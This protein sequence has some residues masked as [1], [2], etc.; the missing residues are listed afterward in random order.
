M[1]GRD[2]QMRRLLANEWVKIRYSRSFKAVFIVLVL[3]VFIFAAIQ[4]GDGGRLGDY[5]FHIPFISIGAF[6]A[7]GSF[8]YAALAATI[9]GGELDRKS[10][11]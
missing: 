10:V 7:M 6:G 2:A 5:G 1:E 9:I 11:V 4:A 8:I 3:F